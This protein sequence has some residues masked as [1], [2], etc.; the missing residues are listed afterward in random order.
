[1]FN[2]ITTATAGWSEAVE[3][4]AQRLLGHPVGTEGG[5]PVD[6]LRL[7]ERAGLDPVMTARLLMTLPPLDAVNALAVI[8]ADCRIDGET[9]PDPLVVSRTALSAAGRA[10]DRAEL[11]P[12]WVLLVGLWCAGRRLLSRVFRT[13]AG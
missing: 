8:V 13:R 5:V 2:P 6:V 4:R 1:M 12:E 9:C 11:H 10:V 7:L 3:E